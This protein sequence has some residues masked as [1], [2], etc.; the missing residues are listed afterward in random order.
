M[1]DVQEMTLTDAAILRRA[2]ILCQEYSG[3]LEATPGQ[4]AYDDWHAIR[5]SY[6]VAAL[7]CRTLAQ[8]LDARE[9]SDLPF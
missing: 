6:A 4:E 9:D 8:L 3:E 2:A 7:R 5:L 1:P